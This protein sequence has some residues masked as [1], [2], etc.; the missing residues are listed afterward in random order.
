[1]FIRV[2]TFFLLLH[3]F[4]PWIAQIHEGHIHDIVF[5]WSICRVLKGS[6]LHRHTTTRHQCIQR[7]SLTTFKDIEMLTW[8]FILYEM[9]FNIQL[10]LI[11]NKN[12][13]LGSYNIT[14]NC[15]IPATW[16]ASNW[17]PSFPWKIETFREFDFWII[18]S[19]ATS[20]KKKCIAN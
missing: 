10:I 18:F 20:W 19:E 17:W 11:C 1:M 8:L 2:H 7:V 5:S 3:Y 15:C 6:T 9:V 14:K 13:S 12:C 4:H 16:E